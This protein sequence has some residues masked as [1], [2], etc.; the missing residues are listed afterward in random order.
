MLQSILNDLEGCIKVR[1]ISPD[2]DAREK[3]IDEEVD[4]FIQALKSGDLGQIGDE[5]AD[6]CFTVMITL[7]QQGINPFAA[8]AAKLDKM[9]IETRWRCDCGTLGKEKQVCDICQGVGV[10]DVTP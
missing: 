3:K 7:L 10:M 2:L 8:M 5:G 6:V 4:E 9:N 1:Q